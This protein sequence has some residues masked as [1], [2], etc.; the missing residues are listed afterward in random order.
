MSAGRAARE[1]R[2][3]ARL[4]A[5]IDIRPIHAAGAHSR[6]S[7]QAIEAAFRAATGFGHAGDARARGFAGLRAI[8]WVPASTRH[9]HVSRAPIPE[10]FWSQAG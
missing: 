3:H 10:A 7:E 6:G 4:V 9:W 8:A 2:R 5:R 1:T